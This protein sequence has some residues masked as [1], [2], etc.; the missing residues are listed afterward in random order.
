MASLLINDNDIPHLHDKVALI[1]GGSSGIGYATAH[2]LASKGCRV[3]M[4][5][6]NT[7]TDPSP[8]NSIFV[9]C[10]TSSWS[11]V[12]SAFEGIERCDIAVANAG[13]SENPPFFE[14]RYDDDGNLV[15]GTYEPIEVNLM[16]T[17]K[18]VK[19]AVSYM[20]R[21]WKERGEGGSIVITAS[22]TAYAPEQSLP[23]YGAS[24]AAVGP[25]PPSA[26]LK[27]T[28]EHMRSEA[29]NVYYA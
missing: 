27:A 15:D 8:P 28:E 1:T 14:D 22:A 21:Q 7:P 4:L 12:L 6:L 23:V 17:F 11:S 24:K 10:D 5:D 9:E 16:G 18:F 25:K 26:S 29:T 13:V 20:R 2:L 3:Y 19:C